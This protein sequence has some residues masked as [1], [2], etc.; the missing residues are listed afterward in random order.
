[1]DLGLEGRRALV[2]GGGRGIARG[3]AESLSAEG[4]EVAIAGRNG[5]ALREAAAEIKERTGRSPAIRT[6]DLENADDIR[7]LADSVRAVDILV[8]NCGGP[9]AGPI[10]EV[11][12]EDWL[13]YFE[14]IFLGTVRL[15]RALLPDMRERG[16]GRVLTI[17]SSGVVQPIPNLGISNALRMAVVGWSK[18]LAGEVATHGVTVNCLAPGRVHTSRIDELDAA[19]AARLGRTLEEVRSTSRATIPAGR[20][21]EV[22]EFADFAAFLASD[23]AG[24]ITGSV[25]RVDGGMIRSM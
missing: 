14:S 8:N 12:D 15:T 23:R 18:T 21:G 20:Y 2:M 13:R 4:A 9:P 11:P 22:R 24:Y 6:C 19:T 5:G 25:H 7:S 3:I 1:M 16:F 10:A 17:V